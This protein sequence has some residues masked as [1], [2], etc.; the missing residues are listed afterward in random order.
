MRHRSRVSGI[1]AGTVVLAAV[2]AGVA[3]AGP[4]AAAGRS[5]AAV[6]PAVSVRAAANQGSNPHAPRGT[7]T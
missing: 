1:V 7:S 5:G 2:F 6:A 4:V 3:G